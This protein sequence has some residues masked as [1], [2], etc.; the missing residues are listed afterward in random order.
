VC[1]LQE[2]SSNYELI[3]I[4]TGG[5]LSRHNL[6]IQQ[7][8]PDTVTEL[9]AF[10]VAQTNQ[11]QDLHSRLVLDHPRGYS[12]QLHKCIVFHFSG[13]AVFDE[14]AKVNRYSNRFLFLFVFN[15]QIIYFPF[16]VFH[17]IS[18]LFLFLCGNKGDVVFFTFFLVEFLLSECILEH[19][20]VF[21]CLVNIV[22]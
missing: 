1:I 4:S 7:L 5:R 12:R 10:H 9:S 19:V 18:F 17:S 11:I 20:A 3:E 14:N 13:H 6:H 22:F 2:A 15:Y 16:S 21:G 8:G